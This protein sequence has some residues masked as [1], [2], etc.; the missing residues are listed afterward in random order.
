MKVS[1][2]LT[3]ADNAAYLNAVTDVAMGSSP[4]PK[5]MFWLERVV[6]PLFFISFLGLAIG[7]KNTQLYGGALF[8]AVLLLA[9]PLLQEIAWRRWL[10]KQKFDPTMDIELRAE[11]IYARDGATQGLILWADV[12]RIQNEHQYV[13]LWRQGLSGLIVPKR[14]FASSSEAEKFVL[15]AQAHWQLARSIAPSSS[16]QPRS[17]EVPPL[18]LPY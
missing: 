16:S 17:P 6:L 4:K 7:G 18:A 9:P 12:G 1:F 3:R 10:R 15:L 14:A 13:I 2:S 11:G 8:C 5:R